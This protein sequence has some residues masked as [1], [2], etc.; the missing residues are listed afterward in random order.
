[1]DDVG[2]HHSTEVILNAALASMRDSG[3]WRMGLHVLTSP[4]LTS[5]DFSAVSEEGLEGSCRAWPDHAVP[6]VAF[7][8]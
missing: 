2:E 6:I 3:N 7:P 8:S 4:V 5:N 1:M